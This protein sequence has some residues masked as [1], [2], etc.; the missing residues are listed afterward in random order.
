MSKPLTEYLAPMFADKPLIVVDVGARWGMDARWV[1]FGSSLKAYCFEADA[2]ECSRLNDLGHSGVTYI[3]EALSGSYGVKTLYVT[4]YDASSGLYKVNAKFFDRL[5]N[6]KNAEV[7]EKRE[8]NTI[9][10]EAARAKYEIPYHDFLKLDVEGAEL[11]VMQ[12][13]DLRGTFGIYTEIRFHKEINGCAPFSEV[14]QF[15]TNR[16][17]M[18]YDLSFSRQS[19]KALPFPGPKMNNPDGSRF[20]ASTSGGQ[21]MDGDA[22]YLRDAMQ[23]KLERHQILKAACVL[24]TFG[25]NDCAAE[26]LIDREKDADIDLIHCLNLLAGGSFR[27]YMESY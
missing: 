10:L 21:V 4:R 2:A 3:P 7:V 24:E 8:V 5:L 9:T 12:G 18:L 22:L 1:A 25:L 6:S 27:K 23:L 17:F 20:F 14:D 15:L 19:R 26:L 11:D 13:A 16:R